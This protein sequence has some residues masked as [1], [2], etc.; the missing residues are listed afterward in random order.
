MNNQDKK[1]GLVVVALLLIAVFFIWLK[2]YLVG[3][4]VTSGIKALSNSCG[5]QY[6]IEWLING[7]WFC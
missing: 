6:W 4:I 2:V 7:D 1:E 5:K 3:S